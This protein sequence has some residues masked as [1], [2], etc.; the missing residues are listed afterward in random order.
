L[1]RKDFYDVGHDVGKSAMAGLAYKAMDKELRWLEQLMTVEN[2]PAIRKQTWSIFD[3]VN[4]LDRLIDQVKLKDLPPERTPP[5]IESLYRWRDDAG[6]L[7][8]FVCQ[9]EDE[10]NV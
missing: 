1:E 6:K 8:Q 4:F 2:Y 10:E 3:L 9:I 5:I 7:A